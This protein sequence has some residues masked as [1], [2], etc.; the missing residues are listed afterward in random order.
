LGEQCTGGTQVTIVCTLYTLLLFS[1][2]TSLI[3]AGFEL[4]IHTAWGKY[5]TK[6]IAVPLE[7]GRS[8]FE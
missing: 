3:A 5:V 1:Y 7:G 8:E 2:N 6:F 4:Y